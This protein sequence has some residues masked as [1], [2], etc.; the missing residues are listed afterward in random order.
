M[1]PG[2][3][4]VCSHPPQAYSLK[5]SHGGCVKFILGKTFKQKFT[6]LLHNSMLRISMHNNYKEFP[7][8]VYSV[9]DR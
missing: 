3:E 6:I 2:N 7:V 8:V 9:A 5:L 1:Y 4:L